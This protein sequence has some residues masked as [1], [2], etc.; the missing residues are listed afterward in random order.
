MKTIKINLKESI[1]DKHTL[2]TGTNWITVVLNLRF[3]KWFAL[4]YYMNCVEIFTVG[5]R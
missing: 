5:Y 4:Y 2:A 3:T 1:Q